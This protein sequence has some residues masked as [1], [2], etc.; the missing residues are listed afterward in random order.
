MKYDV[1]RARVAALGSVRVIGRGEAPRAPVLPP[2]WARDGAPPPKAGY[3]PGHTV[4]PPATC[5]DDLVRL[6][7]SALESVY[8][9]RVGRRRR[10]FVPGKG[11]HNH[12]EYKILLKAAKR[13]QVAKIGV[14]PWVEFMWDFYS[15]APYAPYTRQLTTVN[16]I[17]KHLERWQNRAEGYCAPAVS[18]PMA[19]LRQ[20]AYW[21]AWEMRLRRAYGDQARARESLF[22]PEWYRTLRREGEAVL[23]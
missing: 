14:R 12:P 8:R 9:E 11:F 15:N 10:V 16:T 18:A 7:A 17:E 21:H 2:A 5:D 3:A 23:P 6:I 22:L 13:L 20:W 19:P 1:L 4:P